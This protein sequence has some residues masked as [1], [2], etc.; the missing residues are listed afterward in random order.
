MRKLPLRIGLLLNSDTVP[1]WVNVLLD[2]ICRK[3]FAEVALKIY[4]NGPDHP[5]TNPR[6]SIIDRI[7]LKTAVKLHEHLVESPSRLK[8]ALSECDL[9]Q[10]LDDIPEI[11]ANTIKT[12]W[13]DTFTPEDIQTI[14][15]FNLDVIIRIGFRILDGDILTAAR[16]GV[17]SLHHGDNNCNRGGPPAFWETMQS[18][19]TVGSVLQ[20]ITNDIDNGLVLSRSQ[21]P[22]YRFSLA[23][24]RDNLYWKSMSMISRELERLH[25]IGEDAFFDAQRLP[26]SSSYQFYS[27][28]FYK[29]PTPKEYLSLCVSK[30]V[31][32]YKYALNKKRFLDQW[33]LMYQF[34]DKPGTSLRQYK[35][36]IP[37]IDRFWADPFVIERNNKYY[38][39]IEE[40]PYAA[41]KGHISVI[42]MDKDGN[43]GE[44][45][46]VIVTDY[47]LSY[48]F[49]IEHDNELYMIPESVSN[50]SVELYRC[51]EFPDK[52]EFVQ[53]LMKDINLVDAT[54]YFK[55]GYW[56]MF[57]NHSDNNRADRWDECH[58]YFTEDFRD[59][60]WQS[61]PCNP[62]SNDVREARP[63]GAIIEKDGKLFRPSQNCSHHYGYGFNI[64]EILTMT[65]E[66]YEE[67]LVSRI[68]PDWDDQIVGT[69]TY[70]RVGSL[71]VI[72]AIKMRKRR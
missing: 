20:K 57:G 55:D 50:R 29:Y 12:R 34:S 35:P 67:R 14:K 60:N 65:P 22:V 63:A 71:N 7:I 39:Y 72:D 19:D 32:R 46:Q 13:T 48:P 51:T 59:G 33:I 27:H 1:L 68:T 52:W 49:L 70:N 17:W 15:S 62:I 31:E 16:H 40:Y 28:K 58:L 8:S 54:L 24:T 4:D 69:H 43:I 37:P 2:D 53:Y 56:W 44:P 45:R 42:E 10:A 11:Q 5:N 30:F 6:K 47:H 41:E 23:H 21:S 26:T 25:A 3:S 18:W 38:L 64:F 36:I 66:N 9:T 61:H